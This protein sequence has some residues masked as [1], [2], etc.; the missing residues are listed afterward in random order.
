MLGDTWGSDPTLNDSSGYAAQFD[1]TAPGIVDYA[2]AIAT[3]GESLVSAVARARMTLEMSDAQRQLL[4]VQI[5][6]AQRG[7]P[8]IQ[9]T[10]YTGGGGSQPQGITITPG[11][12]LVGGLA[13]VLLLRK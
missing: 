2:R 6:R 12:L 9:T 3:A 5:D 11:L 10:G 8:P 4:E 13:A 1:A 7:L